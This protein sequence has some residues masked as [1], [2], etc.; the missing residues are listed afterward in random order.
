MSESEKTNRIS[1]EDIDIP[2]RYTATPQW[3]FG[4]N[5]QARVLNDIFDDH[6][7]EGIASYTDTYNSAKQYAET[8]RAK[9]I[10]DIGNG[11]VNRFDDLFSGSDFEVI[12]VNF[13]T[14]PIDLK[15]NYSAA[16]RVECDL[17][18][19]NEVLA[20]A[21]KYRDQVPT[22]VV[23]ANVI[24]HLS[25]PRPLLALIRLLLIGSANNRCFLST[26]DRSMLGYRN[27]ASRPANPRRI[28]EWT[29]KELRGL[30]TA[31]G[32]CVA[33]MDRF[34]ADVHDDQVNTILVE[35]SFEAVS[36]RDALARNG[37]APQKV[38]SVIVTTEYPGLITSGGIGT[39]VADWHHSND[40]SMVLT[41]FKFDKNKKS[42]DDCIIDPSDL[43]DES[44]INHFDV[45]DLLLESVKQLLF[46][47]PDLEEI[48]LQEYLGIGMRIAQAKKAGELPDTLTVVTH[49]HGNQH[50]LENAN[51][52]WSGLHAQEYA[53]KEKICIE[54]SDQVVFPSSFLRNLYSQAGIIVEDHRVLVCPYRYA[55]IN[56]D[57]LE[58]SNIRRIVFV[59]K[60]MPMKG[61]DL[62]CESFDE[63]FCK[64][65]KAKGIQEITLIGRGANG[66]YVNESCI[67][68]H[69]TLTVHNEFGLAELTSYIREHR[70]DS[71]FVEPYRG[72]NFPLAVYDVVG[73]G[74]LLLAGRAGGIPEMF[75]TDVWRECLVDLSLE[76][77]RSKIC[78]LID[79]DGDKKSRI[80]AELVTDLRRS[81][82]IIRTIKYVNADITEVEL[83]SST[84]MIP[85][86]NTN[87]AEFTDLLKSINQQSLH[88]TEV[89]IV[90]DA[91]EYES[92]IK[93]AEAVQ[94]HLNV[95]FRIIDHPY[96]YGLA[97]ARNTALAACKT[98][99]IL[100]A[101]SD[102][103]PLNDWIKTIVIA[104]SRDPLAAAAVPYLAAFDAGTDFN[105]YLPKGQYIY[106]PL[107]DGLVTSQVQNDLGHANSG[108][109]VSHAKS[110]G[111]WNATSKAKYEDWAFYLNVITNGLR[112]AII[113]KVTCLYRVRKNS[114]AR[115]YSEWPGQIR[116]YQ[117][118]G[119]LS[120]FES[121]QLQRL[122]RMVSSKEGL[123]ELQRRL[124]ALES[125]KTS[126]IP[127]AIA[128]RLKRIPLL[129][130]S[131][132]KLVHISRSATNRIRQVLR[133]HL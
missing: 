20:V 42:K 1:H 94:K 25:D 77:L 76:S 31:S 8:S 47:C 120:R 90:N 23:C 38:S 92:R 26:P 117:T 107:G 15:K 111:G 46:M 11:N 4:A 13:V 104:L 97:G 19:W 67:K 96:N 123:T 130:L 6:L 60:F 113:P 128:V 56:A 86:F 124:G 87:I 16:T 52:A 29:S 54:M 2:H 73:N 9:R 58:F 121:L 116:L 69:F 55:N 59:G 131:L 88:P 14:S 44:I 105:Q 93:M 39:F 132:R 45:A 106:R 30:L 78:E 27:P 126:R 108:Y 36:Y 28:R 51:C 7:T 62:F 115:T 66:S 89:I 102:D 43:I 101:D 63:S 80:T 37:I 127:N 5:A 57:N 17:T 50:Y 68:R 118:T 85:F 83:L 48:H 33:Q 21:E 49:C 112:I 72:D 81:N 99:L 129:S 82:D 65:L 79:W 71:L 95:P 18:S 61:F 103:I 109:R 75:Q 110:I 84:V 122:C 34:P 24:E 10:I 100:N 133:Q 3:N 32:L 74:G 12:S 98:D 114:M 91:S 70:S 64:N 41:A 35:C 40:G 119:G 22:V 53:V 125:R